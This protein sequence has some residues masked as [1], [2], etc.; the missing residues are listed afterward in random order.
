MGT[1][2]AL[3][4][5]WY[6]LNNRVMLGTA[7][8]T[9]VM[10][11]TVVVV[12]KLGVQGAVIGIVVNNLLLA[13]GI[14]IASL[15]RYRPKLA[16]NIQYVRESWRYGL[17]AWLADLAGTTNLRLDQWILGMVAAP[18][19]LGIYGPAVVMSELL[20][21]I[22]DSLGFVL[23]NKIAAAA[24]PEE[25]AELVER[26]NRIIFWTM[27]VASVGIAAAGP[28]LI[29]LPFLYGKQYAASA[30]PLALLM[31][32][33]VTFT[34][35]KVLTKYFAGTGSPH[36]SATTVAAGA[37]TGLVLYYPMIKLF[38][39]A[40]AAIAHSACYTMTADTAVYIYRRL[41][42]PRRPHLFRPR[43]SDIAWLKEQ[44]RLIRSRRHAA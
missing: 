2:V 18:D 36:H 41:V 40:G 27:A 28:W 14:L 25:Q 30:L 37:L 26:L 15:R 13:S 42:A 12:L 31:I 10:L 19:L 24:D 7:A 17:K 33:T 29:T 21:M 16:L 3:G 39:A 1:R 38:G 11:L 4:D 23:F 32:G 35:Q 43:W 34:T 9:G 5:S 8:L 6:S 20:W 44:V 22:P